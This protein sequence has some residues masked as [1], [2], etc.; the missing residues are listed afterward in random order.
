MSRDK[1]EVAPGLGVAEIHAHTLA[2][3]GMVSSVELVEGAAKLG[4]SV[5]CITDH[6]TIAKDIDAGIERGQTVG[7]DVVVG[8]EVTTRMR[9]ASGEPGVHVLGLFLERPVRQHM[10]IEDTV[11]AIH[12]EGGLALIPHPFAVWYFASLWPRRLRE[13]LET[14]Q[15][16]G[17]ELRHRVGLRPGGWK[18]LDTFYAAHR[19]RLGAALGAGDSHHGYADLGSW[20]TT[21]PGS[22]A[23]GLRAA[24]EKQ[25]T[26]PRQGVPRQR[27][28]VRELL[29][30]QSRATF[31]LNRQRRNGG[32]GQGVGP[33]R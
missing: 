6:D 14:H 21:F 7:V 20:V 8:E 31:W 2:S 1:I 11:D 18:A 3:D 10:S 16:D 23:A 25:T 15:L 5:V 26:S 9:P 30:Q 12:D 4:L 19:D 13:L 17:I 24:I 29:A 22:G 33:R 32:V 28:P 27:P